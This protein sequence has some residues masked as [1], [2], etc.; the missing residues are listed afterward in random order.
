VLV[1]TLIRFFD[2]GFQP[3]LDQMEH[4]S[5]YDP[6]SHR[7]HKGGVWK[8]IKVAAEVCVNDFSMP[9]VD[10]LVDVSYRVQGAAV[11]PIGILFWLQ[12]RLEDGFEDQNRRHFRCPVTDSGHP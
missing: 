8:S 11:L 5:V 9:S 1:S 10:Q 7:P 2:W 6:A 4:S 3:H 12:I